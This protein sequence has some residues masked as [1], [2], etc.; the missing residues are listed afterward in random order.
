MTS[1]LAGVGLGLAFGFYLGARWV[2]VKWARALEPERKE[3]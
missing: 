1:F 2:Y 3:P